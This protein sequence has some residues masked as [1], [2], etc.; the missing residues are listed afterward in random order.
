MPSITL[1]NFSFL[2][3]EWTKK[4]IVVIVSNYWKKKEWKKETTT[5]NEEGGSGGYA[6]AGKNGVAEEKLWF[7]AE[8]F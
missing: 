4:T 1:I 2:E 8:I 5:V 6:R 3:K 7:S